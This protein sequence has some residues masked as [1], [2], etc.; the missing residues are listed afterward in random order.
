MSL[1]K[2]MTVAL[3]LAIFALPLLVQANDET[4]ATSSEIC[5]EVVNDVYIHCTKTTTVTKVDG[6]E[7]TEIKEKRWSSDTKQV[8]QRQYPV[9]NDYHFIEA[10]IDKEVIVPYRQIT[11]D[12]S[13]HRLV[14]AHELSYSEKN[15]FTVDE[16]EPEIKFTHNDGW[17]SLI[18]IFIISIFFSALLFYKYRFVRPVSVV[19]VMMILEKMTG[20]TLATVMVLMFTLVY[21]FMHIWDKAWMEQHKFHG[22]YALAIACVLASI[23]FS[24]L[25]YG[26]TSVEVTAEV[27]TKLV[28]I[29]LAIIALDY[30]FSYFVQEGL[31][32]EEAM[33]KKQ[34]IE[35]ERQELGK[36]SKPSW[37][38]NLF[39]SLNFK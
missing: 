13:G 22:P 30:I 19:I 25:T 35:K 11:V 32:K 4:T 8:L 12:L 15:G 37:F 27:R 18:L 1:L 21:A 34:K 6:V 31:R 39:K 29:G 10:E 5:S 24:L 14:Y 16:V 7:I 28:L 20:V 2:H 26:Y 9:L 36:A 33:L 17:S 38:L 3:S 23:F